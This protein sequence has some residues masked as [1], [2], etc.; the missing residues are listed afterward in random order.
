MHTGLLVDVFAKHSAKRAQ[1]IA[2]CLFWVGFGVCEVSFR[3]LFCGVLRVFLLDAASH[4]HIMSF[5]Q[6]F[7]GCYLPWS[8][9]Y[10]LIYHQAYFAE[11]QTT[12]YH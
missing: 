2:K 4:I 10:P 6:S 7:K 5:S 9:I 3:G 8:I 1:M 12:P 11:A